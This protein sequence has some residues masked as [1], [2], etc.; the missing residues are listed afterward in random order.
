MSTFKVSRYSIG[1]AV[2]VVVF[3][4]SPIRVFAHCDSMDGPVVKAAVKALE[5]GN[6][7]LVLIW[8][9]ESDSSQIQEAYQKT[10]AVRKL[11]TEARELADL[12][13]FETLVR[14]HRAGEG[15]PYT[16]LKPARL[17]HGPAVLAADTALETRSVK[18]LLDLLTREMQDGLF[19]RFNDAVARKDF[20]QNDVKSGREYVAKYEEF[21]HYV[22]QIYGTFH[23]PLEGHIL[24]NGT[25]RRD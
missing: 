20:R 19:G 24:E 11:N 16:G 21:I 8:V 2:I 1:I 23:N 9:Q 18:P 7:N 25:N 3:A 6:V 5:T 14:I 15:A 17:D 12:W 4:L 22:E 10:I 13:F